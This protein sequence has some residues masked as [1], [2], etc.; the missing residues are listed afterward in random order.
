MDEPSTRE[1]LRTVP[2]RPRHPPPVSYTSRSAYRGRRFSGA[3]DGPTRR[4]LP[5]RPAARLTGKWARV[6]KARRRVPPSVPPP[7]P[8]SPTLTEPAPALDAQTSPG[9]G[10]G[11]GPGAARLRRPRETGRRPGRGPPRLMVTHVSRL[12]AQPP[13]PSRVPVR[14]ARP[15]PVV[16]FLRH[17]SPYTFL[18]RSS[19]VRPGHDVLPCPL[20]PSLH[21]AHPPSVGPGTFIPGWR[22]SSLT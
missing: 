2:S 20:H 1:G 9:P 18:N 3:T 14:A 5:A 17:S 4:R 22:E 21:C 16:G 15:Q 6:A 19:L 13:V 7:P 10:P 8:T 11:P 12:S